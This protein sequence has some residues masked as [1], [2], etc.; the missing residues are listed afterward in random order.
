[1]DKL[2]TNN[3]TILSAYKNAIACATADRVGALIARCIKKYSVLAWSELST[4][5]LAA[6]KV[7]DSPYH[8]PFRILTGQFL[9][10]L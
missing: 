9:Q 4:M 10:G 7:E 1:M 6:M 2:P 8:N 3:P 5:A